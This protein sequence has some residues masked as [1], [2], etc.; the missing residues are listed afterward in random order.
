MKSYE[1]ITKLPCLAGVP[2]ETLAEIEA[3]GRIE[4]YKKGDVLFRAGETCDQVY[5]LLEGQTI[6]YTLTGEGSRKIIFILGGGT[7]QNDSILGGIKNTIFCEAISNCRVF[8]I[9]LS[10]FIH[11]MEADFSLVRA[12]SKI[13]ERKLWRTSHQLKNTMG[14]IFLEKKLAAKLWKL[15]RDFGKKD[16]KDPLR[17]TIQ[18]PLSITFL[19]DLLGAPRETTSRICKNLVSKDLIRMERKTITIPNTDCLAAFY[20]SHCDCQGEKCKVCH[21]LN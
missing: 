21:V 10:E 16:A 17:V 12:V 5:F 20:K 9:P 14:S 18:I 19:A 13:Q 11:F 2:A 7:L 4:R 3:C 8:V 6:I 15:S 1:Q